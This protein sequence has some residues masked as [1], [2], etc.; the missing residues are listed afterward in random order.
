M[1]SL[2]FILIALVAT[3]IITIGDMRVSDAKYRFSVQV[4]KG[5]DWKSYWKLLFASEHGSRAKLGL[6][7]FFAGSVL[8]LGVVVT[9]ITQIGHNPQ[10]LTFG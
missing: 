10:S 4:S 5:I 6:F 9:A 2:T 7:L 3:A 8:L 1:S